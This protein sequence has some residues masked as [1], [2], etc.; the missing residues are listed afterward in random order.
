MT[1]VT[2]T[3]LITDTE[4]ATV[5]SITYVMMRRDRK[6]RGEGNPAMLVWEDL[7]SEQKTMQIQGNFQDS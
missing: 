3:K 2:V 7:K 6:L 4:N 5:F 1:A